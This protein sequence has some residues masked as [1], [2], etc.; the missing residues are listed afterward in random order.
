MV[1]TYIYLEKSKHFIFWVSGGWS[2]INKKYRHK[3]ENDNSDMRTACGKSFAAALCRI[4]PDG[5]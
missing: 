4:S 3:E 5:V 1:S 2:D